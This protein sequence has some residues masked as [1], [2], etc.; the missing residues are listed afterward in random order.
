MIKSFR[1]LFATV[2]ITLVIFSCSKKNTR[3]I[4]DEGS[5]YKKII[6]QYKDE[7]YFDFRKSAEYFLADYPGNSKADY[8][9]YLIGQS[10][11]NEDKYAE[12]IAEYNRVIYRYTDSDYIDNAY[13][14][15][16]MSYYAQIP[17]PQRDQSSTKKA[18]YYFKKALD[19][20]TKYEKKTKQKIKKARTVLAKKEFY[21]AEFYHKR[22]DY[23]VSNKIIN[24][25]LEEYSDTK[26]KSRFYFLKAKNYFKLNKKDKAVSF[27]KM[28]KKSTENKDLLKDIKDLNKEIKEK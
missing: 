5:Y 9:Q 27:L 23:N 12:A 8:I 18:I 17:H 6:K 24:K 19:Y 7:D 20:N 26:V 28:S 2:L 3:V 1:F 13:Y 16:A 15:I 11:Y 21:K 22:K 10:Y 4:M 25:G 14:K